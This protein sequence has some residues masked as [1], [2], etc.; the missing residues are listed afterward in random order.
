MPA[1]PPNRTWKG[2]A[3]Q[4]KKVFFLAMT[5]LRPVYQVFSITRG[6]ENLHQRRVIMAPIEIE[7]AK[8]RYTAKRSAMA[9][10]VLSVALA[11]VPVLADTPQEKV[12]SHLSSET[13]TGIASQNPPR[14]EAMQPGIP[15]SSQ[16]SQELEPGTYQERLIRRLSGETFPGTH[17]K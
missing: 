15:A 16:V 13:S 12:I 11:A 6:S 14:R 2:G 10:A 5:S 8:S 3:C 9:A 4:E 7:V 17:G 1:F